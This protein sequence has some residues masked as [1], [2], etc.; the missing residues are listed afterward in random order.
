MIP[1][2]IAFAFKEYNIKGNKIIAICR[3]RGSKITD[4]LSTT[5]I[6]VRH[7]KTVN[8][9]NLYWNIQQHKARAA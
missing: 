5:S 6:F 3:T 1:K 2:V 8:I 4:A 7:L 9:P